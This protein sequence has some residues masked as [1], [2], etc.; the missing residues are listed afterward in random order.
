MKG[1]DRS[2]AAKQFQPWIRRTLIASVLVTCSPAFAQETLISVSVEPTGAPYQVDGTLYYAPTSFTWPKGSKHALEVMAHCLYSPTQPISDACQTRYAPGNWATSNGPLLPSSRVIVTADPD[3]KWYKGSAEVTH[4][5][6]VAFFD[7]AGGGTSPPVALPAGPC[8]G[9]KPSAGGPGLACVNGICYRESTELWLPTG[10]ITLQAIPYDGFVFTGWLTGSPPIPFV[11]SYIVAGHTV[12]SPRFAP[13]K[14]VQIMTDPPQL[15]VLV[16]RTEVKTFDPQVYVSTCPAPGFFDFAEGSTH[17]LGAP[18]PQVDRHNTEW[19]FDSWSNGGGQNMLYKAERA[20]MNETLV[21]KFVRGVRVSLGIP[22]GLKLIVDGRDTWPAYNFIWGA[23]TRHIVT[24]P[25]E[26][27]DQNGRRYIFKRWSNG[28]PATQEIVIDTKDFTGMHLRAEYERMSTFI[29]QSNTPVTVQVGDESCAT[30]CT[31][32]RE[33]GSE[34]LVSAPATVPVSEG[35]RFELQSFG[36]ERSG[37]RMIK[38]GSEDSVLLAEYKPAYRLLATAVPA[39]GADF[40]MEPASADGYYPENTQVQVYSTSRRGYRFKRWEG[41]TAERFSPAT[42]VVSGPLHLKAI[43][44]AV[45]EISHAGVRNGAG[46]AP[47]TAVAPGSIISVYGAS[48]APYIEAG[49][50]NPLA[51]AIAGVTVHVAG[52]ILPLFFVSP[53]QINAQLPYDLTLGTHTLTVKNSHMPEVSATFE[54]VRAAPGLITRME[55]R[56]SVAAVTRVSGSAVTP[57]K[58]VEAGEVINLFGTGFGP[59]HVSPPDGIGVTELEEFR[60]VEPLEVFVG[61][62]AVVPDYAGPAAG[63]PGVVVL[64]FRTP[65]ELAI[66]ELTNV[67]VIVGGVASNVVVL[68]TAAA[69]ST[70]NTDQNVP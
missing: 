56:L 60:L 51:Q 63:L 20:N 15:R 43:L 24:A 44:E 19:A 61:D 30:P 69:Y 4:R 45:P 70:N 14:R 47:L 41:D 35:S 52:R 11:G 58:P 1:P 10:P 22:S 48:L 57:E 68:P 7:A 8:I 50:S 64:R 62:Q 34:V 36:G 9:P 42:I 29:V 49:P 23:G 39:N 32:H 33:A 67:T 55:G 5:V 2:R 59:H 66:Q 53:E 25:S 38:L 17:V 65:A 16:D 21:A 3:I 13:A 31:V 40:R 37:A 27:T 18:S 54:V 12:L 26:Q 28:G 46:E 6:R